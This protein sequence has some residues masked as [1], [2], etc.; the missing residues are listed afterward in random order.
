MKRFLFLQGPI[1]PFFRELAAALRARG[2][3]TH[4]INLCLGDKLFWRGPGAVDF[5]GPLAE[6]PAFV[7]DFLDQHSITDLVLLGE[8]RVYHRV[9]IG[10]AAARSIAVTAT[11]FGYVRPDWII[12]ERDGHNAMSH[13]PR[14]PAEILRLAEGA[15]P[16]GQRK[17][18]H[19]AFAR[20]ARW[21]M[22]FHMSNLLPWPFPHFETH[23]LNGPIPTY[24]GTGFRLAVRPLERH[25]SKA[26]MARL[27][28][29]A[30]MFLFAMQMEMDFSLRAY[31]PFPDLDTPMRE[32]IASF[33]AHAPEAAHLVFKTHPLDPGLKW[34]A[35]RLARMARAAGVAERVHF[36][37]GAPL[38][39]MLTRSAG[40]ITVNS[41][42]ALYALERGCPVLALGEAVYRVPGLTHE[43][44]RDCF[45]THPEPPDPA[46][47]DAF[48]RAITHHLHVPGGYYD[49]DGMRT[50]IAGAAERLE[51]GT[52]G[53]PAPMLSR[54]ATTPDG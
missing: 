3:V 39:Q 49:D 32:T 38:G 29:D 22:L 9:A 11:D 2:H 40:M 52:V 28:A 20:Q 16:L 33:A 35:L 50:A 54:Q 43:S 7:A 34:W 14:Q 12:L 18:F 53:L 4:R 31:S 6:W 10:A 51:A 19:D 36:S 41:S 23:L 21:D 25:R 44:G 30:P 45:W 42:A 46:L 1:S 5:R 24:L 15:P 8:Q 17:R 27:P 48:L 26:L 47:T 37:D 13:F